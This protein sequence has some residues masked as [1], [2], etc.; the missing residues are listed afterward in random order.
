M[1]Y[2]PPRSPKAGRFPFHFR[3]SKCSHC[4]FEIALPYLTEKDIPR[5]K[6][7]FNCGKVYWIEEE[8]FNPSRRGEK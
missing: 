8:V 1:M 7:C 6:K 2:T 5:K 4:G 3:R